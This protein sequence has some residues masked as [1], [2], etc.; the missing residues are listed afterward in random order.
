M[1]TL[2]RLPLFYGINLLA[3]VILLSPFSVGPNGFSFSYHLIRLLKEP[4]MWLYPLV[5]T[6]LGQ[7][8]GFMIYYVI[9]DPLRKRRIFN[10]SAISVS[11][12]STLLILYIALSD[13]DHQR[14]FGNIESN[15]SFFSSEIYDSY[16][17]EKETAFHILLTK[18]KSPN[19][20]RLT[21]AFVRSKDTLLNNYAETMHFVKFVYEKT[22]AS[23]PY[24]AFVSILKGKGNVLYYD[25]PLEVSDRIQMD[26]LRQEQD[27]EYILD[28][29]MKQIPDSTPN[30]KELEKEIRKILTE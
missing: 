15:E 9:N 24:K 6:L 10:W 17:L 4:G 11:A 26:S 22:E 28:K 5:I 25:A 13:L 2:K 14:R 21:G 8:I 1:N 12:V 7:G 20:I 29:V 3:I 18:M 27:P 23:G 19:D 16:K 30:K